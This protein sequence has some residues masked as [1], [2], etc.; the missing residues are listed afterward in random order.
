MLAIIMLNLLRTSLAAFGD[1]H[2]N[3]AGFGAPVRQLD[4]IINHLS[5]YHL[6][7]SLTYVKLKLS[8][9]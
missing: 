5:N 9:M 4:D 2:R 8:E 3:S 1:R 6:S 7:S